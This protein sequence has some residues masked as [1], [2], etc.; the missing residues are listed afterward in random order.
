MMTT[1]PDIEM[2]DAHFAIALKAL[3]D[4]YPALIDRD[5]NFIY[6]NVIADPEL[7]AAKGEEQRAASLKDRAA[8]YAR[9]VIESLDLNERLRAAAPTGRKRRAGAPSKNGNP[10]SYLFPEIIFSRHQFALQW[11]GRGNF[12]EHGARH[13]QTLSR[14]QEAKAEIT[15]AKML[16]GDE[17]TLLWNGMSDRERRPADDNSIVAAMLRLFWQ[18]HA[19]AL[20]LAEVHGLVRD[21]AVTYTPGKPSLAADV[22]ARLTDVKLGGNRI[23]ARAALL[24]VDAVVKMFRS[25]DMHQ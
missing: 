22:L 17:G 12:F 20:N 2:S 4:V 11:D 15:W 19:D 21:H 18:H 8:A 24:A 16:A 25:E 7:R 6:R 3:H 1:A 5:G 13:G 14:C 23:S 9:T 10:F